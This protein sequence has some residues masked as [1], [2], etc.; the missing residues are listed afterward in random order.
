MKSNR[1]S[2]GERRKL[3]IAAGIKVAQDRGILSVTAKTVADQCPSG[4]SKHTVRS[5][6]G[7]QSKLRAAIC[8]ADAEVGK[9]CQSLGLVP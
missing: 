5:H 7:T 9:M 6:F 3:I 4:C 8:D 2:H 1:L